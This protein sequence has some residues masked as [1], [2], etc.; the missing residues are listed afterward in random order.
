[1]ETGPQPLRPYPGPTSHGPLLPH[2]RP[3]RREKPDNYSLHILVTDWLR[4]RQV[5]LR[6]LGGP[7]NLSLPATSYPG[8]RGGESPCS[9]PWTTIQ[10]R[11]A[12][13][14]HRDNRGGSL[15]DMQVRTADQRKAKGEH[16]VAIRKQGALGNPGGDRQGFAQED[17]KLSVE[18]IRV[19]CF[20]RHDSLY[21]CSPG[22]AG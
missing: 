14:C 11:T 3:R 5:D 9:Q 8:P 15:P 21:M 7:P 18:V 19:P 16:R 13:S 10:Q 2:T 6:R 1:M 20:A 22:Y 4:D 17:S 12:H